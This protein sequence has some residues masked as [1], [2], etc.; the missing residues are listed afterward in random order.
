MPCHG[1]LVRF[2]VAI[3]FSSTGSKRRNK[4]QNK[5]GMGADPL[6]DDCLGRLYMEPQLDGYIGIHQ[7]VDNNR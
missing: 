7:L 3:R 6:H 5:K 2:E 4:K 1:K